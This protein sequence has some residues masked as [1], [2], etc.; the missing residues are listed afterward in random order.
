MN[1][2]RPFFGSR[3]RPLKLRGRSHNTKRFLDALAL[4]VEEESLEF[5]KHC[6]GGSVPGVTEKISL[7]WRRFTALLWAWHGAVVCPS[8]Q[9]AP[10][11]VRV[12]TMVNVG[13][14]EVEERR[15]GVPRGKKGGGG[16]CRSAPRSALWKISW[17]FWYREFRSR[18]PMCACRTS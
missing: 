10:S 13:V 14:F 4:H 9:R 16:S 1:L 17:I 11:G 3:R 5:V 2:R 7:K 6:K 15:L 18:S 8:K 12:L